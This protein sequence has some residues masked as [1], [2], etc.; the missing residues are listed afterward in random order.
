MRLH[1]AVLLSFLLACS[2]AGVSQ[3]ASDPPALYLGTAWYPEQWRESRWDADLSPME[4]AH[5][6]FVRITEFA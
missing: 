4:Q 2:L 6:R 1:L 3:A 5:V